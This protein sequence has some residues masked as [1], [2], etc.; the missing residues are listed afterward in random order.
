M[1]ALLKFE[2]VE[3]FERQMDKITINR[4]F[5]QEYGSAAT[6]KDPLV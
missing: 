1:G 2:Y 6:T 5:P 3:G 4:K